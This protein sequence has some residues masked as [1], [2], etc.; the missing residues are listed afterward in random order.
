MTEPA[1][2]PGRPAGGRRLIGN[3]RPGR[4]FI[5][6]SALLL[7]VV[8]IGAYAVSQGMLGGGDR[9][10]VAEF[11]GDT[12]RVTGDFSVTDGWQIH[13]QNDGEHFEFAIGGD[14][15]FG[16]VITQDAPGSGVTSP[17]P[18]GTFHLEIRATGP[19][20]VQ[21]IQP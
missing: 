17:T 15:N 20:T 11:T 16:T 2:E 5:A 13:W 3:R 21:I 9:R 18:T 6:L 19:W 8:V 7:V 12:D 1:E 10:V 4:A 14:F